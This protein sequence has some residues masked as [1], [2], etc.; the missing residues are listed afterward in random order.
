MRMLKNFKKNLLLHLSFSIKLKY[1]IIAAQFCCTIFYFFLFG[2]PLISSPFC[3]FL[4][5]FNNELFSPCLTVEPPRQND[6]PTV[7]P[8]S[9]SS[10]APHP[11]SSSRYRERRSRRTH[12]SG[13][14][15][16]DRYR[17]GD[18]SPAFYSHSFSS[19]S[20][21]AEEKRWS[22]SVT[23]LLLTLWILS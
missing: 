4:S 3:F 21:V 10:H 19:F 5:S 12:R 17:S 9:S 2:Q 8:S 16:D 18:P 23:V 15:R 14:T 20:T 6:V 7:A 22:S 1:S 13:G 11:S